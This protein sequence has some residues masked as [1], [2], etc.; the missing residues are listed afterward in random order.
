MMDD[1][2]RDEQPLDAV[3]RERAMRDYHAPP[4][5]PREAIWAELEARIASEDNARA[6][7]G[8]AAPPLE[9][10][11]A[12][13]LHLRPRPAAGGIASSGW[14]GTRWVGLA[15]AASATLLLGVGIGRMTAPAR[16][17]SDPAAAAAAPAPGMGE[18]AGVRV[19]AATH[20]A[21]SESLL[22]FVQ[23]DARTGRFDQTVG[24]WGRAL[25]VETRLL[26]DSE[27]GRDPA[28]RDLLEDLELILA[29]VAVLADTEAPERGR[30]ELRLIARGMRDQ[31]MMTRLQT[32]L[33][34]V[35]SGLSGT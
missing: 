21:A 24:R 28:L 22:S 19:V 5:T 10:E 2:V 11:R 30:E 35:A 20:L 1:D 34:G 33:P 27:A 23:A 15:V 13:R 29:Q 25:L 16:Q 4:P 32:A 12:R 18:T 17:G 3:I 6:G 7:A 26:L 9:V 8:P 31:D 14:S